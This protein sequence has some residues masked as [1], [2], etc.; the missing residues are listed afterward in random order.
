MSTIADTV[1]RRI[2]EPLVSNDSEEMRQRE[3]VAGML[4]IGYGIIRGKLPGLLATAIGGGLI[5]LGLR[6]RPRDAA[7]GPGIARPSIEPD[8]VVRGNPVDE[9]SWESFPASD[10]PAY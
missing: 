7:V 4:L 2:L 9:A 5:C 10:A 6:Q 1:R 8:P 3:L